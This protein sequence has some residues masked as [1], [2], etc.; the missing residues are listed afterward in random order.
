MKRYDD[1]TKELNKQTREVFK[2]LKSFENLRKEIETLQKKADINPE[3]RRKLEVIELLDK[4]P[5]FNSNLTQLKLMIRKI[6]HEYGKLKADITKGGTEKIA[7]E[8][9]D[10]SKVKGSGSKLFLNRTK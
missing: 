5:K 6:E 7:N 9:D 2:R 1:F 8:S 10:V 4:D 3:A